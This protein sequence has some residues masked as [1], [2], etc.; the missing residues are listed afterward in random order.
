MFLGQGSY[1][2][3]FIRDNKAVKKFGKLSHLIQEYTALKYLS[4]CDYIVHARGV[5]FKNLE[6]HMELYDLSLR[7]WLQ[8]HD[9]DKDYFFYINNIIHDI[10]MGLIELHDRNLVHGDLKPG[11]ILVRLKPF[12]VVLGD[13]GFVSIYKYA[14]VDKTAAVYRDPVVSHNTSHDMFSFGICLLEFLTKIRINKQASYSELQQIT[15]EK[16]T[17]KEYRRII[18]SLLSENKDRRPTAREVFYFFFRSS[19]K[20]WS[21][22]SIVPEDFSNSKLVVPLDT[23]DRDY[24]YNSMK[25]TCAQ[26]NINRGKKGYGALVIYISSHFVP[27]EMY[28][29]Y[30]GVTVMI[31]SS[32]FGESGFYEKEVLELCNNKYQVSM[33]YKVLEELLSDQMFIRILLCP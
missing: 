8:E 4:D 24:I 14:K 3:V 12:K 28:M 25:K 7:K 5:D 29:L 27:Y 17:N 11:N 19:P 32:I 23:K 10:L 18:S 9:D 6:I 20:P 16:V 31:L 13:C 21:F 2:K 1:G 26:Y 22:L 33:V 30:I 15:K